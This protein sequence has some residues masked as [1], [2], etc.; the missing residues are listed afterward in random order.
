MVLQF[1]I[2]LQ[3]GNGTNSDLCSSFVLFSFRSRKLAQDSTVQSFL[4]C[5]AFPKDVKHFTYCFIINLLESTQS[6]QQRV[7]G[8]IFKPVL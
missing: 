6:L 1:S 8:G 4:H 3:G 2:E 5:E 7:T